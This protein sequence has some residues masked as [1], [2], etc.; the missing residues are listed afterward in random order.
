MAQQLAQSVG[1]GLAA[2]VVHVSLSLH[3]R[4]ALVPDDAALAYFTL[5]LLSVASVVIFWRLPRHAGSEL[6]DRSR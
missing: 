5:G 2:I 4:T 6:N 1:V 3:G